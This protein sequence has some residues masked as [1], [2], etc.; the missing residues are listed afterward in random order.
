MIQK[1]H[2]AAGAIEFLFFLFDWLHRLV[3][4]IA[5]IGDG[6]NGGGEIGH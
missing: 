6:R 5:G 4:R 2:P 3:T 1:G